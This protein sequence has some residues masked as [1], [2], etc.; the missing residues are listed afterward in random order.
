MTHTGS[1]LG[2]QELATGPCPDPGASS[3][4]V[5]TLFP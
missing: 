3:P 5:P 1:F 4:H 2:S